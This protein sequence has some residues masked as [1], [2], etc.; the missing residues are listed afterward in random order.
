MKNLIMYR[1]PGRYVLKGSFSAI[2]AWRFP[3]LIYVL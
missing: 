1:Y 2:R 3:P